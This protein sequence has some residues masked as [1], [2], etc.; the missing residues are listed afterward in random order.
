MNYNSEDTNL[1]DFLYCCEELGERPS[2]VV[3][4]FSFKAKEFLDYFESKIQ[5]KVN[6]LTEVIPH[7][8]GSV[9][10]KKYLAKISDEV[11]LSFT[12]MDSSMPDS[13]ISNVIFYYKN[14]PELIN[15]A[16]KDMDNF[17]SN[18]DDEEI[19]FKVTCASANANNTIELKPL[20]LMELD[21]K[22]MDKYYNDSTFKSTNKLIKKIN[23]TERGLSIIH[24][25]RGVGKTSLLHYIANQ[26]EKEVIFIPISMID[27]TINSPIFK[28]QGIE[29]T[30]IIIDDA[31]FFN[32]DTY[33]KANITFA[34]V[35]QMVDGFYSH[36]INVNI[37]LSFNIE[38]EEDINEDILETNNLIDVIKIEELKKNRANKLLE[39][40]SIK[41]KVDSDVILI[42]ILNNS[43]NEK[44]IK[45]G[46]Q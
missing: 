9:I 5:K 15:E 33:L 24:G 37:L 26:V 22:N 44:P 8:E 29:D 6:K 21:Y 14:E 10:N 35:L 19:I 27:M 11:F 20:D 39:H 25:K 42:D 23:K 16:L 4:V 32:S 34:N 1:N 3:L 36:D 45:I 38:D 46:Y 7:Y 30:L 31:E 2:K 13:E 40:L 18:L 41:D 12:H 28:N 17:I 43:F